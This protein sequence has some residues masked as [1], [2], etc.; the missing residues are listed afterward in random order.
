MMVFRTNSSINQLF[1]FGMVCVK[2]N[3]CRM[4]AGT[5]ESPAALEEE[6]EECDPQR[7]AVPSPRLHGL[8]HKGWA[9]VTGQ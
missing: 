2:S 6:E 5:Q 1:I 8:L 4:G 7:S 3:L 9:R